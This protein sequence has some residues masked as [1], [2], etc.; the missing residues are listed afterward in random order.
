MIKILTKSIAILTCVCFIFSLGVTTN[1]VLVD[2][3]IEILEQPNISNMVK[4]NFE[5]QTETII[6]YDNIPKY[7]K[8]AQTSY[9]IDEIASKKIET[10]DILNTNSASTFSIINNGS[11]TLTPPTINYA[12]NHPYSGVVCISYKQ[13]D[14]TTGETEWKAA[15]GFLVSTNVVVTAAHVVLLQAD[16][17]GKIS[18]GNFRIF[19]EYNSTTIPDNNTTGYY[20]SIVDMYYDAD[21]VTT[22]R[23]SEAGQPLDWAIL[24][25]DKEFTTSF[26]F[27][28]SYTTEAI[29]N[30]QIAVTGYP[31]CLPI[32]CTHLTCAEHPNGLLA[33][34]YGVVRGYDTILYHEANTR[35][36]NS[37]SPIY[38]PE[39]RICYAIHTYSQTYYE[40]PNTH[41]GYLCN[42]GTIIT[43]EIFNQ[44]CYVVISYL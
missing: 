26:Q 13:T 41:I 24:V 3:I 17:V 38:D 11:F 28:Y 25:I 34:S 36:A 39:T 4:Y 33:T 31:T 40:N 20:A 32:D 2:E 16:E 1:A 21:F 22:N 5:T 14:L 9:E 23:G 30:A 8:I 44:I 29:L 42:Q 7:S 18:I 6:P 37:G 12:P 27:L 19:P 43:E 15:T 10:M 35:G